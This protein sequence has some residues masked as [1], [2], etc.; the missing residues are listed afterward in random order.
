MEPDR[1]PPTAMGAETFLAS[2]MVLTLDVFQVMT[3]VMASAKRPTQVNYLASKL[4]LGRFSCCI[5]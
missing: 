5:R 2:A 1:V 3:R 4:I